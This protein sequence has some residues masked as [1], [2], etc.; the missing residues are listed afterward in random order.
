MRIE[1][2]IVVVDDTYGSRIEVEE[3]AQY[4]DLDTVDACA[5]NAVDRVKAAVAAA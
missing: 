1:V 5:A 3:C 2:R 4:A